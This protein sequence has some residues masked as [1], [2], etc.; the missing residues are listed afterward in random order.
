MGRQDRQLFCIP[1]KAMPASCWLRTLT[2]LFSTLRVNRRS[3]R[4]APTQF[5]RA[6]ERLLREKH[7]SEVSAC[8]QTWQD[9]VWPRGGHSWCSVSGASL[10]RTVAGWLSVMRVHGR[11]NWG[12]CECAGAILCEGEFVRACLTFSCFSK[13]LC[14]GK[15]CL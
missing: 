13:H 4:R 15:S 14:R 10:V 8:V 7:M 6:A 12:A 11:E 2:L 1:G 5:L 9:S 3:F